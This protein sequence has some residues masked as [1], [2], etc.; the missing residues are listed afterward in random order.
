[1]GQSIFVLGI[2]V[3]VIHSGIGHGIIHLTGE[4]MV[5]MMGK[6]LV[7]VLIQVDEVYENCTIGDSP[8]VW[9]Y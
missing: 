2:V 4:V 8:P 9:P 1:M 7:G 6:W 5:K 3:F